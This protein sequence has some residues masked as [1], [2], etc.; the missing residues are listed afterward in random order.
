MPDEMVRLKADLETPLPKGT[1][2]RVTARYTVQVAAGKSVRCMRVRRGAGRMAHETDFR[3]PTI[4]LAQSRFERENGIAPSPVSVDVGTGLV[5]VT[6]E[7]TRASII[8]DEAH[9][10]SSL[11]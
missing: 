3:A 4:P 7:R 9:W 5:M 6:P 11:A 1:R 10:Q 2:F 8:D